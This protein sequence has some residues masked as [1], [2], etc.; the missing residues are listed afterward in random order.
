MQHS[1]KHDLYRNKPQRNFSNME[2]DGGMEVGFI[3]RTD[4]RG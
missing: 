2:L 1:R 3:E 4:P